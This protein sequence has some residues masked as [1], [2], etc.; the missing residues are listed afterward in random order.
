D[1]R[2]AEVRS[3]D[4]AGGEEAGRAAG[5]AVQQ[6]SLA[7]AELEEAVTLSKEGDWGKRL[8]QQKR[9]LALSVESRL[10]EIENAVGQALPVQSLRYGARL[11]K[12]APKLA[13][14]PDPTAIRKARSLL[15]FAEEVRSSADTGGF[16][17]TRSR[18]LESIEK[19]IDPYVEE[20]LEHLRSPDIDN[21][22][23]TRAF[24]EVAADI[25]SLAKDEKAGQIVRRRLAA[26]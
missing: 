12:S 11:I 4:T 13:G 22:D 15:A 6:A 17:S 3:F 14:D 5:R 9:S 1:A 21:P 20:L 25:L 10:K 18:I 26:A 19:H 24:L 23:R 7:I 8:A 16:G 2:L